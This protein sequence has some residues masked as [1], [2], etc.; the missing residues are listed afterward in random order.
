MSLERFIQAQEKTYAGALAELKAGKKTGHWIW[1]ILPQ[2]KRPNV[3][4][5]SVLY[6]LAD[7]AEASAYLQHPILGPRYRECIAA[8]YVHLCH[9]GVDPEVLM[10]GDTDVKKLRSSLNYFLKVAPE[11]DVAF[12][13]QAQD[14]LKVLG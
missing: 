10:G 11:D 4:E 9:G 1:W 12:R 14:I 3:S 5:R 6:A 8:V 7:E 13:G 2:D